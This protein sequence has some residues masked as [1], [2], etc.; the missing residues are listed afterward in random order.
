MQ[1][2]WELSD[3]LI[4]L[5]TL[6]EDIQDDDNLKNEDKEAKIESL[7]ENWIQSSDNF[8]EK[9]LRVA[10]YIRHCDAIA[11]ARKEESKRL[12][13][14]AQQS[15]RQG[16]RL[17]QYLIRQMKLTKKSKIEGIDGK[18]SLRKLPAKVAIAQ[19]EAVPDEY[20]KVEVSP[21]LTEIKK[22]IK[23]DPSIDWAYLSDEDNYSLSIR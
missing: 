20:L 19:L 12:R 6:I 11:T 18:I 2:L 8:D 16:E 5:E 14:L 4:T 22:A 21:R 9:A 17:R 23:A 3:D 1:K 13:E 7:F 15:E 10:A